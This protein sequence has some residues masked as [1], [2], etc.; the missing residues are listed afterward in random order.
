MAVQAGVK[1][2]RS[3]EEG[4]TSRSCGRLPRS[5]VATVEAGRTIGLTQ[6]AVSRH[7]VGLCFIAM[8]RIPR[9]AR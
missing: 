2:A 5:T 4:G 6:V 9:D 1:V 8:R 3:K 7:L